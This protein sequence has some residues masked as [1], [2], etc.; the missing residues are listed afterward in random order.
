MLVADDRARFTG[1]LPRTLLD[2]NSPGIARFPVTIGDCNPISGVDIP[3]DLYGNPANPNHCLS[4]HRHTLHPQ[5]LSSAFTQ[6]HTYRHHKQYH[7]NCLNLKSKQQYHTL[8]PNT[9][10]SPAS[11]AALEYLLPLLLRY[12]CRITHKVRLKLVVLRPSIHKILRQS[13]IRSQRCISRCF[14]RSCQC[15][16]LSDRCCTPLFILL[17]T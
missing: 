3:D 7:A 13:K 16:R 12:S 9:F 14:G 4:L 8:H 10:Q 11:I 1:M 6:Y 17:Q 15:L 2:P 5:K